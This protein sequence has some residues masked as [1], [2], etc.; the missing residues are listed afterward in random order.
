MKLNGLSIFRIFPGNFYNFL[1]SSYFNFKRLNEEGNI[2]INLLTHYYVWLKNEC[3]LEVKLI[4][5]SVFL[6]VLNKDKRISHSGNDFKPKFEE[7]LIFL[8]LDCLKLFEYLK[9]IF[10][11]YL[12]KLNVNISL[13]WA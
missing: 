7:E 1:K 4:L 3:Y 11:K 8:G 2:D 6:E 5:A 13:K 9:M 10:I 12:K